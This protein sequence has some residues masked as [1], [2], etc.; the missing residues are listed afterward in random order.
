MSSGSPPAD[1]LPVQINGQ[2]VDPNDVYARDAKN[3]AY[4]VVTFRRILN[5]N[6][7]EEL[8][9]LS[10]TILED[11]GNDNFLCHYP[12]DDLRPIREKEFVR[13]VDVYR[14]KFKIPEALGQSIQDISITTEAAGVRAVS[15]PESKSFTVNILTHDVVKDDEFEALK[16]FIS[17]RSGVP[18]EDLDFAPGQVRVKLSL[19]KLIEIAQDDR[20]RIIEE[21]LQPQLMSST[22]TDCRPIVRGDAG[23]AVSTYTGKCQIITVTDTGFDKGSS[24]DCHPAF[25]GK[26]LSLRSL[27]RSTRPG[28]SEQQKTDDPHGHGTHVSG[29]IVGKDFNTTRGFIGGI[30]PDAKLIL[31]SCYQNRMYNFVLPTNLND[32][33]ALPYEQGSRIFSNSWGVGSSSGKQPDY[34]VAAEFIDNFIRNNPEVLVCFSAG[35]DNLQAPGEPTI[36][37]HAGAKNV[38]TVGATGGR[39]APDEMYEKSSMGPSKQQRLKPDVVAPGVEIFSALSQVAKNHDDVA[40]TADAPNVT[41]KSLSGTSQA[42]PLVAGC[43]AVL[44]E[45]LQARDVSNP[46]GAL[47]KAL[48]I[49]GADRIPSV[50]QNAQGHGRVN[51]QTSLAMLAETP[52]RSN[53]HA[54]SR[55]IT[56]GT[57]V[58]DALKQDEEYEFTLAPDN[59]SSSHTHFKITMVYNDLAHTAIQNNLNLFVTDVSTSDIVPGNDKSLTNLDVQNNVEQIILSYL[60]R[61]GVKI[62]VHAQKIL[63]LNDQDYVLAWSVFTPQQAR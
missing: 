63:A 12:L 37:A 9:S 5:V 21:D 26:V 49:N 28:L 16:K 38:L 39:N 42:A 59:G 11:L 17:D 2:V 35:N 10:V 32:V 4:I 57:L 47:L 19:D 25:T 50:S 52:L 24:V 56:G 58:G 14:N 8:H 31:Q 33:F 43:A 60:P 15:A 45:A 6:E 46:P 40:T 3:T 7:E 34:T 44:R 18:L 13:Q 55:S 62:R 20:V 61:Q 36:G 22:P 30:A 48:I 53:N 51:L 54:A 29:I 1:A 27:A 23:V 41:W